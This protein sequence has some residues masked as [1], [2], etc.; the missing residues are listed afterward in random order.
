M[1]TVLCMQ[2]PL[3][4]IIKSWVLIQNIYKKKLLEHILLL[5][6]HDIDFPTSYEDYIIFEKLNEDIALNVLYV[7]YERKAVC[8]EYISP[9]NHTAK[10]QITLLKIT[11]N[12]GK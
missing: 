2:Q 4:C 6:W 11:D 5:N 1:H 9:H 12:N 3:L 10:K 8:G 7:P